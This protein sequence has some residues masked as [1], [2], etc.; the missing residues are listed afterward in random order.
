MRTY[1]QIYECKNTTAAEL[2]LTDRGE[3]EKLANS[4]LL[5]CLN[6][7]HPV[8][9]EFILKT[10]YDNKKCSRQRN[11]KAYAGG[12]EEINQS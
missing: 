10:D 5:K 3:S 9:V 8:F 4:Y 6:N 7:L 2:Y 12:Y 1:S 11:D